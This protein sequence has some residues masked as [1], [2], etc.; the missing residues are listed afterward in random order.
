MADSSAAGVEDRL[1]PHCGKRVALDR[2]SYCDHCGEPL[3]PGFAVRPDA[4]AA[5]DRIAS[6]RGWIVVA[7]ALGVGAYAWFSGALASIAPGA[8]P[9]HCAVGLNG[10]AVSVAI[11]GP[12][13]LAQCDSF[14]TQTTDGG[15]WYVYAN[16]AQPG[17]A[18]ICQVSYAGDEWA[19]RDDGA[20]DLYGS[21][22]CKNLISMA[23][24]AATT[25]AVSSAPTGSV[26]VA[27]AG[28]TACGLQVDGANAT[29]IASADVCGAFAAANP[30]AGGATWMAID[31]S[32]GPPTADRDIC[33]G[34]W[35]GAQVSVW[36]SGLAYYGSRLCQGLGWA[37]H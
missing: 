24:G 33:D 13:A 30:P 1:C 4:R 7:L 20:L 28:G 3:P 19:V 25:P 10:A 27:G 5:S 15:T 31:P 14:L 22:I 23:N 36:D 12:G 34:T 17:G 29:I 32:S 35:S 8:A 18:M 21:G 16:G 9:G 26:G 11:D 2:R 37:T 6:A